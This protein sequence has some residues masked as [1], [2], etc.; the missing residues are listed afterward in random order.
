[1]GLTAL[2]E[3]RAGS[4]HEPLYFFPV[5]DSLPGA[6]RSGPFKYLR[7]T[8]DLGRD[9]SHLSRVDRDEEGH[10]LSKLH[11]EEAVRLEAALEKMRSQVE[12]NPRGW[13]P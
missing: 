7:S 11:P 2:L 13:L 10:E 3:G 8:G 6:V 4:P 1:M 12:A 5:L 9:R